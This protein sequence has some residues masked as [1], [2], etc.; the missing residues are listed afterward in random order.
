MLSK[1]LV[2][3]S[4]RFLPPPPINFVHNRLFLSKIIISYFYHFG[5]RSLRLEQARGPS[6]AAR[7]G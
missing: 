5:V 6:A 3:L 1:N 2:C 7:I 4:E